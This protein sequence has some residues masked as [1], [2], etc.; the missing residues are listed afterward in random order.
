MIRDHNNRLRVSVLL[1]IFRLGVLSAVTYTSNR[2]YG[3][4]HIYLCDIDR[5]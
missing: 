3:I 1:A 5:C 4:V 2:T